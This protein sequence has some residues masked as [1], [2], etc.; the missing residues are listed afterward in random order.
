MSAA[1]LTGC[2]PAFDGLVRAT[3]TPHAQARLF[4]ACCCLLLSAGLAWQ[5]MNLRCQA[6]L[7]EALMA[8]GTAG[9]GHAAADYLGLGLQNRCEAD[10]HAGSV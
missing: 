8:L 3:L 10:V 2:Q 9:Q 4:L 6:E 5:H 7:Y 1:A